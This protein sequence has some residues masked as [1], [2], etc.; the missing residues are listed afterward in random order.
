M[1]TATETDSTLQKTDPGE[2]LGG[3]K[4]IPRMALLHNASSDRKAIHRNGI[5]F[6]VARRRGSASHADSTCARG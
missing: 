4:R 6:S 2:D 1:N 5:H 3:A